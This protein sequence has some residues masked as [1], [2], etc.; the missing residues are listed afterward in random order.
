MTTQPPSPAR[1]LSPSP[2]V[3]PLPTLSMGWGDL[4]TLTYLCPQGGDDGHSGR[5]LA[6]GLQGGEGPS[7]ECLENRDHLEQRFSTF[8]M[9]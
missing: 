4:G 3:M 8:V 1:P 5:P 7:I 2:L 6:C 9:P